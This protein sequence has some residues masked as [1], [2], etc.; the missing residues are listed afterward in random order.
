MRKRVVA[1]TLAVIGALVVGCT[2]S[3]Q[4]TETMT[5]QA[6]GTSPQGVT[7]TA[8]PQAEVAASSPADTTSVA[9]GS[10]FAALWTVPTGI[11][12][13]SRPAL[14]GTTVAAGGIDGS[15]AAYSIDGGSQLWRVNL[16]A[17]IAD[18]LPGAGG[19]IAAAR[20]HL[21]L[22]NP[23][24]GSEVARVDLDDAVTSLMALTSTSIYVGTSSGLAAIDLPDFTLRW[25]VADESSPVVGA[26][27]IRDGVVF[28]VE[29]SGAV[30]A[31]RA[32]DGTQVFRSPLPAETGGGG[33]V[34]EQIFYVGTVDQVVALR[35]PDGSLLW[36]RSVDGP[37][38]N[39]VQGGTNQLI[40]GAADGVIEARSFTG[41]QTWSTRLDSDL[42]GR[43]VVTRDI[44]VAAGIDGRLVALDVRDGSI[45]SSLQLPDAP[46]TP[47]VAFDEAIWFGLSDGTICA[48]TVGEPAD[49]PLFSG[50]GVWTLPSSGSFRL[51][52][53]SV[54]LQIGAD[55]DRLVEWRVSSQPDEEVIL[56]VLTS[57]G[58]VAAT[59]MGKVSLSDSV[60]VELSAGEVYRLRIERTNPEGE[61]IL[62]V[63]ESV[64][65]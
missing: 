18:L 8:T 63:I 57:D 62:S 39:G 31:L 54:T 61:T 51:R 28:A 59:N 11:V 7:P 64:L 43:L 4:P 19:F 25:A 17:P 15:V 24:D 65:Q 52:D 2:P 38:L 42:S 6:N 60:R 34:R 29:D 50:E 35:T 10:R 49:Q 33:L 58:H 3:D 53:R 44:V 21:V 46:V 48:V 41:D 13:T 36:S 30:L 56:S 20:D 14:L 27:T 1:M 26:L 22:L 23:E 40:L 9:A 5:T 47:A 55:A 45:R 12:P 16:R 32:A 37:L